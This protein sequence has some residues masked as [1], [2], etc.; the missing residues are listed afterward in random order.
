MDPRWKSTGKEIK[1]GGGGGCR[2]SCAIC[3][4]GFFKTVSCGKMHALESSSLSLPHQCNQHGRDDLPQVVLSIDPQK[5]FLSLLQNTR[6]KAIPLVDRMPP[7]YTRA[8]LTFLLL[9]CAHL[10]ES[11][12]KEDSLHTHNTTRIQILSSLFFLSTTV[13]DRRNGH[14]L[15]G[16]FPP[17]I[18]F[19]SVCHLVDIVA[20]VLC[21]RRSW[22]V[23]RRYGK[24]TR[25]C[26][27][28]S[29]PWPILTFIAAFESPM[30][31]C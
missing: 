6:H 4:F 29:D 14:I 10:H 21:T 24:A 18:F 20:F 23:P 27:I 5:C 28:R 11:P 3:F 25:C 19:G 9:V 8:I 31:H 22:P 1:K 15:T 7:T 12:K 17:L 16:S 2:L 30:C 26:T 13:P